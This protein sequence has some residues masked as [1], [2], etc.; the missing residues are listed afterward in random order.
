MVYGSYNPNARYRQRSQ[1]RV[2]SGVLSVIFFAL[3]FAAGFGVGILRSG[4]S[5]YILNQDKKTIE[6]QY[7]TLQDEITQVRAEAQTANVRLEQLKASHKDMLASGPLQDLMLLLKKQIDGGVDP[8]RIEAV[9]LSA[10]PPKNC[11][12]PKSRRLLIVTPSYKGPESRISMEAGLIALWGEGTSAKT[13]GD[14]SETWFDPSKPVKILFHPK[15]GAVTHKEGTLPLYH[16]LVI[17]EKEYRFTVAA[18]AKSFVKITYDY[19]DYP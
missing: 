9:I 2:M 13:Q 12:E 7:Q 15:G 1:R 19:C 4:Q 10:R 18:D 3:V 11:S 5:A 8:K 6:Q 17:G 14:E 16:T